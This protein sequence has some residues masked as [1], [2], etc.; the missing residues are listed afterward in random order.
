MEHAA[1]LLEWL[2]RA[3]PAFELQ[4][5]K[6]LFRPGAIPALAAADA[7]PTPDGRGLGLGNLTTEEA[8]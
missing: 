5:R 8:S 6:M 3:M 2:R 4:L 7:P 1:M